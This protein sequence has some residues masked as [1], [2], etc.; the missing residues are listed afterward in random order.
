MEELKMTGKT[1][2]QLKSG[3][4]PVII[5]FLCNWCSY[6]GA[7]LAGVARLQYPPNLRPIRVMCSGMV[8]PDLV[9][10]AFTQGADGVIVMGCHPGECHYLEGNVKAAARV[11][12]VNLFLSDR[13]ID[14]KRF[15]LRWIS[16]AEASVF[17]KLVTE[18]TGTIQRLGPLSA[19]GK[20]KMEI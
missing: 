2:I 15:S 8:S 18:F 7:D 9:V 13:G 6:T 17:A 11:N 12:V 16:S 19:A 5:G 1:Q 3:F 4:E 14:P 20:F 10:E